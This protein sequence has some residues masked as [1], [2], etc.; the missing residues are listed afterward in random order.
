LL[1]TGEIRAHKKVKRVFKYSK[2]KSGLAN[3]RELSSISQTAQQESFLQDTALCLTLQW[4]KRKAGKVGRRKRGQSGKVENR[5]GGCQTLTVEH[6][7]AERKLCHNFAEL[8][9]AKSQRNDSSCSLIVSGID[10]TFWTGWR[11]MQQ[12][13]H[14]GKD[15]SY[16]R[17]DE[18][19]TLIRTN[20]CE[21][22]EVKQTSHMVFIVQNSNN[23]FN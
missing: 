7:G 5:K 15:A 12:G 22:V 14:F 23:G 16:F 4:E 3:P 1:L 18:A 21:E 8:N 6:G 19:E 13:F 2:H 11:K 10:C 9:F 20:L 17:A